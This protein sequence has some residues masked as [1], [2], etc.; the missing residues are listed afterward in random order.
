MNV[1]QTLD[2]Q[3]RRNLQ[4]LFIAGLLFWSS[5]ASLLPTL[6]LYI[7]DLGGTPQQIGVVMGSF[8]IGLLICVPG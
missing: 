7:N 2:P 4:I 6:P 8:A 3:P 5:L 1:F